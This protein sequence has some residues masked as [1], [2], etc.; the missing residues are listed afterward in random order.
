M[1][2]YN[3]IITRLYNITMGQQ[4]SRRVAGRM[5]KG[6]Q[7]ARSQMDQEMRQQKNIDPNAAI[8]FTRGA[9][10]DPRDAAQEEFLKQEQGP[11]EMPAV[12]VLLLWLGTCLFLTSYEREREHDREPCSNTHSHLFSLL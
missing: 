12:R 1:R 8:G 5:E 9:S 4:I 11:Q 6:L 2:S 10:P 3:A 7:Q